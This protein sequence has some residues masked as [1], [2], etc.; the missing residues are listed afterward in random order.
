MN[1]RGCLLHAEEQLEVWILFQR[2]GKHAIEEIG[3]ILFP[4]VCN[5]QR[6]TLRINR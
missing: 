3:Y 4:R 2:I 6:K 5:V 1:G